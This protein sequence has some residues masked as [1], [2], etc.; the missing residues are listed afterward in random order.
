M[1][2]MKLVAY[3]FWV[4]GLVKWKA[5]R[6]NKMNL[7]MQ[8]Q[9]CFVLHYFRYTLF[10]SPVFVLFV[11]DVGRKPMSSPIGRNDFF[12]CSQFTANNDNIVSLNISNIFK[13]CQ[14]TVDEELD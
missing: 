7:G 8:T 4:F 14:D 6:I 1:K 3:S 2:L 12:C 5:M 11:C 10:T 13:H 9:Q